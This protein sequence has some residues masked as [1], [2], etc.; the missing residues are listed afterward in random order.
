MNAGSSDGQASRKYLLS[1]V[2]LVAGAMA[3]VAQQ[4]TVYLVSLAGGPCTI[5]AQQEL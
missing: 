4:T 5:T 3:Y 1:F 2:L